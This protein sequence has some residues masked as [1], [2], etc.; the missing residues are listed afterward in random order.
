MYPVKVESAKNKADFFSLK[1]RNMGLIRSKEGYYYGNFTKLSEIKRIEAFC[2]KKHLKYY[3][4]NSYGKRSSNYR[5][6]FFSNASP[7][8]F[9]RYFC[10]YC[11][12]L[13]NASFITVDHLYPISKASKSVSVQ[14]ILRLFGIYSINSPKNL[15]GACERCN[16]KKGQKTGL[17]FIRGLIGRSNVLWIIRWVLRVFV[18]SFLAYY[19]LFVR[20]PEIVSHM[21]EVFV[22]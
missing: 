16:K 22:I 2:R 7:A 11:G 20:Y 3:L 17:W 13:L 10:A 21:I 5:S 9:N 12:K 1:L 15:V 6:V 14:S 19:L 4:D 8:I 18:L